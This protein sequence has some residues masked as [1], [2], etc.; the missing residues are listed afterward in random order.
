MQRIFLTLLFL[1]MLSLTTVEAQTVTTTQ[2]FEFLATM[3]N[4]I[5]AKQFG[6]QVWKPNVDANWHPFRHGEWIPTNLGW[7]WT[8]YEPFGWALYHYGSWYHDAG[9][10]WYWIPGYEFS[11][12]RVKWK[13]SPNYIGWSP[14]LPEGFK[15]PK[16]KET[17]SEAVWTVVAA[18]D[19]LK[20]NI[21][22]LVVRQIP[23]EFTK[24]SKSGQPE[25]PMVEK[26][27]GQSIEQVQVQKPKRGERLEDIEVPPEIKKRIMAEI[28]KR[29]GAYAA[30]KQ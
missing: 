4:W 5:E 23:D 16:P 20:P 27:T 6:G 30:K 2:D 21:D 19:F 8:S 17:G 22:N 3:G 25:R 13:T 18:K 12:A 1:S 29:K 7:L 14:I 28:E 15:T 26:A 11:P 10:G 24:Q 9:I